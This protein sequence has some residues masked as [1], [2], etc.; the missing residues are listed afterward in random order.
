MSF[1]D[2]SIKNF[3]N[4]VL[5]EVTATGAAGTFTGAAGDIIDQKFAGPF[6]PDENNLKKELENQVESDI[7]KRMFTDDVTPIL[8]VDFIDLEFEYDYDEQEPLYDKENFINKSETNMKKVGIDIK[9][10]D[11]PEYAGKNFINKSDTN[12]EYIK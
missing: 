11:K 2:D 1:I 8:D 10:D 7:A 3:R 12:W 4:S 9:Y 5:K 6:K